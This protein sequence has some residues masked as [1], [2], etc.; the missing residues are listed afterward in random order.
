MKKSNYINMLSE[1]GLIEVLKGNIQD[2]STKTQ[3]PESTLRNYRSGKSE[4]SSMP[5][6][7]LE[8]LSL[9]ASE[10][11]DM[12]DEPN[13]YYL[14]SDIFHRVL[15]R[16]RENYNQYAEIYNAQIYLNLNHQRYLKGV[17]TNFEPRYFFI[18][19]LD[20]LIKDDNCDIDVE[21]LMSI[22]L[23]YG[24]RFIFNLE[25]VPF[26]YK[27]LYDYAGGIITGSDLKKITQTRL[28]EMRKQLSDFDGVIE[29]N[30]LYIVNIKMMLL[31]DLMVKSSDFDELFIAI[32]K[33]FI[34]SS[35]QEELLGF[36]NLDS[37]QQKIYLKVWYEK[38]IQIANQGFETEF[39]NLIQNYFEKQN[40]SLE[41]IRY[42]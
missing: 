31:R 24:V 29:N 32:I 16:V 2:I 28:D 12:F 42:N 27:G 39:V 7:M 5:F 30:Q 38:V 10:S 23:V 3:I 22:G 37:D 6:R 25:H 33:R 19:K 8:A 13:N 20:E 11:Y 40:Y 4:I 21:L 15:E 34:H 41:L 14:T 17:E 36:I 18:D 1:N 9:Y 26:K 35:S